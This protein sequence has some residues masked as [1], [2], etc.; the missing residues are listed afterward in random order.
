MFGS[1]CLGGLGGSAGGVGVAVRERGW[2]R[3]QT[4]TRG[5]SGW[6][7]EGGEFHRPKL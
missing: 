1:F 5:R 7:K 4:D 2:V 6:E 3:K